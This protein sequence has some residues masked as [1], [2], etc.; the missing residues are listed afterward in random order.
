MIIKN[1]NEVRMTRGDT[2]DL[3]VYCKHKEFTDGDLLELTIRKTTSSKHVVLH[4]A[5]TDFSEKPGKVVFHFE[6]E[7]TQSIPCGKYSY[8]VQATFQDLGVK[9]IIKPALFILG[10][11]CTYE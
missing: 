7:D 6:P 8:D 10:D 9:T 4:K 3:T 2:D 5:V 1:N 11:E